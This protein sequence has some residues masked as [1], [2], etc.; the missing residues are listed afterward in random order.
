VKFYIGTDQPAHARNFPRAFLS[1]HRVLR[2][3]PNKPIACPDW[4]M[5]SGAFSELAIHGDYRHTP[6]E[7]AAQIARLL[8]HNPGLQAVVSQDWMCEPA[9]LARTGL[10]VAEH[11]RRTIERYERLRDLVTGVYLMPVL[12]GYFVHEYLDHIEQYGSRLQLGAYVGVGSVCKRNGSPMQIESIL[13]AIAI[14]R[15]DLQLHGFGLK[16]IALA[17]DLVR[18]CLYSAD[19][20]A[21]SYA[22]RREGRDQHDWREA[23]AYAERI[24]KQ[25]VQ[26]WLFAS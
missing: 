25:P 6:A 5:D 10:S 23:L 16:T 13:T 21:W 15:P 4:I 18:R 1:V 11:Q 20:M 9:M 12:Q 17:S 19:S 14:A 2:R 24:A 26:G 22:A 3:S 7:Y 8:P